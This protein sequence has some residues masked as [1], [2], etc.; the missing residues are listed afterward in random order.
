MAMSRVILGGHLFGYSMD[1][2]QTAKL[3]R[4]AK[5]LGINSIDTADTYTG[6][7]SEMLIGRAIGSDRGSWNI[8]S[9]IGVSADVSPRGACGYSSIVSKLNSSLKRLRTDYIDL[10][11]IHQPD[12]ITPIE[13]TITC[14]EDQVKVGKIRAYGLSNFNSQQI[15]DWVEKDSGACVSVQCFYNIFK[16]AAEATVLSTAKKSELATLTYGVLGRGVITPNYISEAIRS[17]S[18]RASL[19]SNVGSDLDPR[20]LDVVRDLNDFSDSNLGADVAQLAVAWAL[21][22]PAIDG[23]VVGI[24]TIKSLQCIASSTTLKLSDDHCNAI[25]RI[26][27]SIASF[28]HLSLGSPDSRFLE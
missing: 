10:Y 14:L 22:N 15:Y 25:E 20:I 9:K 17:P 16:R 21:R 26:V 27:G 1:G 2:A 11:Q 12:P 28:E 6:G 13:E 8:L 18:N 3:L 23:T 4:A 7:Q 24:R 19:S 5:E